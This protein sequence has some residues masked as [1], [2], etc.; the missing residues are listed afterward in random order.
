MKG[1][2]VEVSVGTLIVGSMT[3]KGRELANMMFRRKV[4]IRC[5]QEARWKGIKRWIWI[6]AVLPWCSQEEKWC[7][8][9][10]KE[11]Y[12]NVAIDVKSGRRIVSL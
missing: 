8:D 4:D 6:Q 1:R 3:C 10:L 7:S 11:D 5:V 2:S 12:V 9:N